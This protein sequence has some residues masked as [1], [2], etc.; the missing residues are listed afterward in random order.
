MSGREAIRNKE[1][2]KS[3]FIVKYF[4]NLHPELFQKAVEFYQDVKQHN[5]GV[6]DLTKTV[7]FMEKV[8]PTV[9]IP[10]Y[11]KSRKGKETKKQ[12]RLQIPLINSQE[13]AALHPASPHP[14][15]HQTL[16][17]P[18][19]QQ[20]QTLAS[21]HPQH[22]QTL[23]SPHPQQQQTLASPHPQQQQTLA[24]PHPQQQQTLASPHPQQQQTL[25]SPHPQQ[26]QTLSSPHPQ[27]QPLLDLTSSMYKDLLTELQKDPEISKIMD[28][29]PWN[30]SVDEVNNPHM[31]VD[32]D[33]INCLIWNDVVPNDITLLENELNMH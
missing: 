20:Q 17:S 27:E 13:V 9:P 22:Q 26:Q 5:P 16:A 15:Q 12:M 29:F 6:F 30:D 8:T 24:S 18:H 4:E 32:E 31:D 10:R 11:Y 28:D 2:L 25:V 33:G 3:K 19:P 23:A 14:Q 7:Q 21:P 1:R